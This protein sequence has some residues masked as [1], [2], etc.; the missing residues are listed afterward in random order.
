V[1]GYET[2]PFELKPVP[3]YL[4]SQLRVASGLRDTQVVAAQTAAV[5]LRLGFGFD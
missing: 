4:T 5:Q 1:P 3:T 2:E